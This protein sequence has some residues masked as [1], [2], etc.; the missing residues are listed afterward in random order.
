MS[1]LIQ[2]WHI[3][4][5]LVAFAITVPAVWLIDLGLRALQRALNRRR[6]VLGRRVPQPEWRARRLQNGRFIVERR[7]G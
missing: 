4:A 2:E 7:R 6:R 5:F 3:V 1:P